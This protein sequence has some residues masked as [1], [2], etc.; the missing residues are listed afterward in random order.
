MPW[1]IS[2]TIFPDFTDQEICSG[3]VRRNLSKKGEQVFLDTV[4]QNSTLASR[5]FGNDSD[6][7]S[8]SDV[9]EEDEVLPTSSSGSEESDDDLL[10]GIDKGLENLDVISDTSYI[11]HSMHEEVG[12]LHEATTTTAVDMD[13]PF[14][15][16]VDN[17]EIE[18]NVPV[19]TFSI[20]VGIEGALPT[21][22]LLPDGYEKKHLDKLKHELEKVEDVKFVCSKS[23]VLDLFKFC[24]NQSCDAP[25]V[26]LKDT[27]TGCTLQMNWNCSNGHKGVWASSPSVNRI[28]A[29]NLQ[30]AASL[31]FTGNNFTKMSLFSKCF[32]LKFI[33]NMSFSRYQKMYLSPAIYKWWTF[34]QDLMYAELKASGI[35][36]FQVMDKWIHQASQQSIAHTHSWIMIQITSLM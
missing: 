21:T 20:E 14:S 16:E 29:N 6:D 36:L 32:Q 35:L 33:S 27:Y 9:S 18:I 1:L 25:I 34:T 5:N 11:E 12:D 23:C 28:F 10:S 19:T 30:A 26:N 7:E 8:D 31:L 13:I 24:L 4:I 15:Q 2:M 3:E 22:R 17:K